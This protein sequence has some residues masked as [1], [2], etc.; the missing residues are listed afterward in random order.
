MILTQSCLVHMISHT[1]WMIL[2]KTFFWEWLEK[3]HHKQLMSFPAGG[4]VPRL[5]VLSCKHT[6]FIYNGHKTTLGMA[7][8]WAV[9]LLLVIAWLALT[10]QKSNS[11]LLCHPAAKK[12]NAIFAL[13]LHGGHLGFFEGAVLFP[14]PLTW[15]DKVIVG[16]ANAICQ[17]EKQK[18]P[19]Q[20]PCTEEKAS[21][22]SPSPST[23]TQHWG[24]TWTLTLDCS[25][26]FAFSSGASSSLRVSMPSTTAL[27]C[28]HRHL[29]VCDWTDTTHCLRALFALRGLLLSEKNVFLLRHVHSEG[30]RLDQIQ[31]WDQGKL[32]FEAKRAHHCRVVQYKQGHT[33]SLLLL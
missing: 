20:S 19:C 7:H 10:Q 13:T 27:L 24:D 28:N 26:F 4:W 30:A 12:P 5:S 16:Y 18:P 25:F 31:W 23:L 8:I 1:C 14:Q 29:T 32:A 15:M 6:C 21:P 3:R 2:S 11:C 22:H 9:A 33:T 17:W